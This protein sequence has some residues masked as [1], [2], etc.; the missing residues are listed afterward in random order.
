MV[1]G[2]GHRI[3]FRLT[4][5]EYPGDRHKIWIRVSNAYEAYQAG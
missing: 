2:S 4:I 1:F 5:S 3:G